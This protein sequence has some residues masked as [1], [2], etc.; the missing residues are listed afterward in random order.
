MENGWHV[1]NCN[2]QSTNEII[3]PEV[4]IAA[5]TK[6]LFPHLLLTPEF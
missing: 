3:D 2:S 5:R 6:L 1:N 4:I